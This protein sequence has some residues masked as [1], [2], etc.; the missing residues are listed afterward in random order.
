MSFFGKLFQ[1]ET[2]APMVTEVSNR[3]ISAAERRVQPRYRDGQHTYLYP[4]DRGPLEAIISD[5][6]LGGVRMFTKERL[7]PNKK[8]GLVMMAKGTAMRILVE[9]IWEQDMGGKFSYGAR[10]LNLGWNEDSALREHLLVLKA[11]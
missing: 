7:A 4:L 9:T 10:F 2:S 8:I 1:K 11:S 5:V 6:S 3:K